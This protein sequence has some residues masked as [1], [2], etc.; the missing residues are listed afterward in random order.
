MTRLTR[1]YRAALRLA[2]AFG[3]LAL[4]TGCG[5]VT[6]VTGTVKYKGAP[7]PGGAITVVASNGTV[8][9]ANVQADGTFSLTGVPTGKAQIAIVGG[10]AASNKPPPSRGSESAA[11]AKGGK[12]SAGRGP[13]EADPAADAAAPPAPTGPVLPAQYGDPSTSGLTVTITAGQP[14]NIDLQ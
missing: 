3:L 6:D 11:G 9:S 5:S 7:L 12:V 4:V 13:R 1:P 10:S 2:A 8:H 14:V